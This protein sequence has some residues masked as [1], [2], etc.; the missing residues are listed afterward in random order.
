MVLWLATDTHQEAV[1]VADPSKPACLSVL[2]LTTVCPQLVLAETAEAV[3]AM[4]EEGT[5]RWTIATRMR[6]FSRTTRTSSL[7]TIPR[8]RR[9]PPWM[10]VDVVVAAGASGEHSEAGVRHV[11]EVPLQQVTL[12]RDVCH[13][14]F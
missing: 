10:Y 1:A 14:C 8:S 7:R 5:T 2:I 4:V 11:E 13:F 9:L 6:E 3:E 12:N